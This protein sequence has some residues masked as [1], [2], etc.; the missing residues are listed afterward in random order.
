MDFLVS[1]RTRSTT[2]SRRRRLTESTTSFLADLGP[3]L[4]TQPRSLRA[5]HSDVTSSSTAASV[6]HEAALM[7]TTTRPCNCQYDSLTSLST[8]YIVE[9]TVCSH[10][11]Q[12]QHSHTRA[13]YE[14]T[15]Y[16]TRARRISFSGI[17][18]ALD[19][20]RFK[21]NSVQTTNGQYA[22]EDEDSVRE[23]VRLDFTERSLAHLIAEKQ[24]LQS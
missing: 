22:Y 20:S 17:S 4:A 3:R 9:S 16:H 18:L 6:W 8:F 11:Q 1:R 7:T 12:F 23:M 10:S 14:C 19:K 2:T 21:F 5:M 15:K 24:A 13:L